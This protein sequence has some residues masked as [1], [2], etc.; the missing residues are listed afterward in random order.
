MR[1]LLSS[2]MPC[3][4]PVFPYTPETEALSQLRPS[5]AAQL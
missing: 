5:Q 4:K 2:Q 3:L 1:S